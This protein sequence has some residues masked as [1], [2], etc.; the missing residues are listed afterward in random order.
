MCTRQE[1]LCFFNRQITLA[2]GKVTAA[3]G[4]AVT[5]AVCDLLKDYIAN[6][7]A[8]MPQ[9]SST[10][11]T[12]REFSGGA[13]LFSNFTANTSKTLE[14]HFAGR[15]DALSAKC[16]ALGGTPRNSPGYDLSARFT[17]LPGIPVYLTFNDRDECLP[18][19]A[20]FLFAADADR[21]LTVT[22]LM[23][24]ATSLTG[25]LIA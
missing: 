17:A 11:L 10:L 12:I 1:T 22:R 24:I 13:P 23:T 9:E 8:A 25:S 18:A 2:D 3:D 16:R 21:I 20:A 14:T 7:P 5:P 15:I 4:L 6:R 19:S